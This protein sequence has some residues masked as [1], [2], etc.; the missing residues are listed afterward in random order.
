MVEQFIQFLRE[1]VMIFSFSLTSLFFGCLRE[2]KFGFLP[3]H[4]KLRHSNPTDLW[5]NPKAVMLSI[6]DLTQ[7]FESVLKIKF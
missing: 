5:R 6:Y 3:L 2:S 7:Y 4:K 1:F